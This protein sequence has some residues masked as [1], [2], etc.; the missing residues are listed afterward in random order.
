MNEDPTQPG[1]GEPEP[2]EAMSPR[3]SASR[4]PK[5][6]DEF[7][8]TTELGRGGMGVVY[9]AFD[10]KLRRPVAIKMIRPGVLSE[11]ALR[12]FRDEPLALASL[13]H[14][15][16]AVIHKTGVFVEGDTW[17]GT[18]VEQPYFVMEF[19][20]GARP[21]T[22]Y[23]RAEGLGRRARLELFVKIC[24][25]VQHAHTRGL[26][27]RDLKPANILVL[28]D[29]Q[30]KI[31]DFGVALSL[32]SAWGIASTLEEE[33]RPVGTPHYMAPEQCVGEVSGI[34]QRCD[35]Y[36]LG[37]VLYELVLEAFPYDLRGKRTPEILQTIRTAEPMRPS[38]VDACLPVG[39]EEVMLKALAGDRE[40]R[41]QTARE[42]SQDVG[43]VLRDQLPEALRART[44]RAAA[45]QVSRFARRRPVLA[46]AAVL[47]GATALSVE[48]LTPALWRDEIALGLQRLRWL[49]T[50]PPGEVNWFDR[51]RLVA[52]TPK[53]DVGA[54]LRRE[55]IDGDAGS[56]ATLRALHARLLERLSRTGVRGVA[57]DILFEEPS[58]FDDLLRR[59]VLI[60]PP[61]GRLIFGVREWTPQAHGRQQ[62][63]GPAPIPGARG[64]VS[65]AVR[66]S[67]YVELA[68]FRRG[69]AAYP[70]LALAALASALAP[71]ARFDIHLEEPD[72]LTL[73]FETGE[74]RAA[75]TM[76][77]LDSVFV[78]DQ[79]GAGEEPSVGL[80][81]GDKIAVLGAEPPAEQTVNQ[82]TLDYQRVFEA[83][84]AQLRGWFD[85]KVVLVGDLRDA[86]DQHTTESGRRLSGCV[87]HMTAIEALL[88]SFAPATWTAAWAW[89][90]T[91]LFAWIGL[92]AGH[93][94]RAACVMVGV[95]AA[96]AA[97][98]GMLMGLQL[99]GV[100]GD[101]AA[102]V[103][104][105]LLAMLGGLW[106]ERVWSTRVDKAHTGAG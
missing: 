4:A 100:L 47:A 93:R 55:K 106:L 46:A 53:T 36:A 96:T 24:E 101:A 72:S 90:W 35:V 84:D 20:G 17:G 56:V 2:T 51:T 99:R 92:A 73:R 88:T 74:D 57:W 58:E 69:E 98:L 21:L 59:A 30:P 94:G 40:K 7:T 62:A 16:I 48:V 45:H 68:V 102:P 31:I 32:G 64:G 33:G 44:P 63:E 42:L 95:V 5:Q 37:V 43:R 41:Y 77:K 26:V 80:R 14:P 34:D 3:G 19:L 71:H 10:Q 9:K 70:S 38:L 67:M 49:V 86:R 23:A 87:L 18:G 22:T 81:P 85:G 50:S 79:A 66:P 82:A 1:G 8:V 103:I 27:H 6:I 76:V 29:G 11:R 15:N 91:G 83:D 28:P 25:T 78:E 13:V 65:A 52:I 75:P 60:S 61:R 104:G 105:M 12:R 89:V 39:L 54:L 97:P